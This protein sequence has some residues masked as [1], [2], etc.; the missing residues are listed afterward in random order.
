MIRWPHDACQDEATLPAQPVMKLFNLRSDPK[1][2]ADIKDLSPWAAS[3]LAR[4]ETSDGPLQSV[5]R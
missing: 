4:G 3:V 5:A 2:E 1:E